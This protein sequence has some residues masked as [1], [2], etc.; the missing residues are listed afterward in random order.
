MFINFSNHPSELWSDEQITAAKEYGKIVDV[1][2]PAVSIQM[3]SQKILELAEK[4]IELLNNC[5]CNENL[6]LNQV[7][8]MCQG[9]FSLTYAMIKSLKKHYPKCKIVCA[10]SERHVVEEKVDN[11]TVKKIVFS[12]GGFREYL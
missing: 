7:T 5:V 4:Q 1:E 9:E 11:C 8:I 3:S 2:F 6:T 12:F 10:T